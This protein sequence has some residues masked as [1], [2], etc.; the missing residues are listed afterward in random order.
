M[1]AAK[2]SDHA[3]RGQ[4]RCLPSALVGLILLIMLP[5]EVRCEQRQLPLWDDP[6][7]ERGFTVWS[8]QPG[9]HVEQGRIQPWAT[10]DEPAWGLA[11]WSSRYTLADRPRE[12]LPDKAVRFA[13]PAKAVTFFPDGADA[14]L[15][16]ALNGQVEYAGRAPSPDDPWPHL[17]AERSLV[18]HPALSQLIRLQ[19]AIEYRLV[20][21]AVSPFDHYNAERHTAQFV[22]Y[23][24]IQNRQ[25]QSPGFGD[26]FWF[27]VPLYDAR[28]RLP[29]AHK[30]IDLS[31]GGKQGTG[32]FIFN[33]GGARYATRSA[34]EGDWISID[35]D[36][37]PLIREGLQTAWDRGF[38]RDSQDVDDY[39]LGGMNMG[40]EVTGPWD[41][42]MQLRRLR[43]VAVLNEAVEK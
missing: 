26:Y 14:D 30:A 9:Q 25:P 10:S 32:K 38:L 12:L 27:C 16:L 42:E 21:A 34:H 15:A 35:Q 3:Q 17:L 40:W 22:F 37:L 11:Q 43:L 2:S 8:P 31:S 29:R 39:V 36:V 1:I 20:R 5:S 28:D 13:D 18:A 23:L 33:P 24:T 6:R 4:A 7:F 41:V 19:L